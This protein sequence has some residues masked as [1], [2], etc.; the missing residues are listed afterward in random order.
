MNRS[1]SILLIVFALGCS[2]SSQEDSNKLNLNSKIDQFSTLQIAIKTYPD[3]IELHEQM[4]NYLDSIKQYKSAIQAIDDLLK[5]DS[6]NQGLWFRKGELAIK[7][8]DTAAAIKYFSTSNAIYPSTGSMLS[9]ANLLAEQKNK[10]VLM[11]CKNIQTLFPGNEYKADLYFIKGVYYART[12]NNT[13]ANAYF[14]SCLN[15]NYRYLE[16]LMEKGFLLYENHSISAALAIFEAVIQLDPLYADGYFWKAKC[17]E[18]N[19]QYAN[20]IVQ[21]EKAQSLDAD[22]KEAKEAINRLQLK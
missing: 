12:A 2:N 17:L 20:A 14:D 4:I 22:L 8:H 3:S 6:L 1:I 7:L 13:K 19:K 9:I 21:Y 16:A 5:K 11:V 10:A 15:T 18:A